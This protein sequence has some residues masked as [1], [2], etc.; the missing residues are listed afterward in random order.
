MSQPN[1]PS[2][3][4]PNLNTVP[5]G[6]DE[7]ELFKDAMRRILRHLDNDRPPRRSPG[8]ET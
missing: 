5:L 3:A 2:D 4:L 8:Q 1:Y 7:P 6:P